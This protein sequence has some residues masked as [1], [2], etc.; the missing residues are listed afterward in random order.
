MPYNLRLLGLTRLLLI[1]V[2][3]LS[4]AV[5]AK[6]DISEASSFAGTLPCADCSGIKWHLDLWPEG[7]FHLRRDY[8]GRENRDDDLG[9]WRVNPADDSL[10][11]FG[12]QE[13]PLRLAVTHESTLR[14]LTPKGETIESTLPYEL[15]K[16]PQFSP[17]EVTVR[18][19]GEFMYFA[20][21]ASI[22]V[23]R[24]GSSYPVLME[25]HYLDI[26][27]R[28]LSKKKAHDGKPTMFV[29]L[30]ASIVNRQAMDGEGSAQSLQIHRLVTD[31]PGLR[32]E[33]AMSTATLPTTYWRLL[34]I[35]GQCLATPEGAREIHLVMRDSD[36][37][38]SGFA[39]C[40]RF[41]GSYTI[42]GNAL[43]FTPLA[44]TMMACPEAQM[45]IEQNV[46]QSIGR[47]TAWRLE[48]QTLELYDTDGDSLMVF[49][50]V[51]LP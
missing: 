32:C 38:V 14:L 42:D 31:V 45:Q 48:G 15:L 22:K 40:N 20:D 23:C 39:G 36:G 43:S 4:T 25:G 50:A 37:S 49:D 5:Q 12:A 28:Y 21:A 27:R 19:G 46:H 3:A 30:E 13:A 35:N 2:L 41:K 33:R 11:L 10:L 29:Q 9:R 18:V 51:Y 26:E 6:L 16:L 7:R 47:V 8:Q 44:S 1:G 34:S 17:A 24:T